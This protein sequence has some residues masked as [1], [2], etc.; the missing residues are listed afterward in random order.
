MMLFQNGLE[1]KLIYFLIIS[2]VLFGVGL[3]GVL[4]KRHLIHVLLSVELI[5]N[6]V[7]VNLVAF[8]SFT[9][10]D[11]ITGQMFAVFVIVVAACEV[12]VGL[13]IILSVY[14]KKKTVDINNINIL[15]W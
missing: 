1:L 10:P 3:Y 2:A 11:K 7:L 12:G 13:A 15:K 8:S 6:A 4:T 5:L 9:T 14:R